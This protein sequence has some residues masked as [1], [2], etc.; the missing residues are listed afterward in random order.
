MFSMLHCFI[1]TAFELASLTLVSFLM[2]FAVL[3][4][5]LN[6][7][8]VCVVLAIRFLTINFNRTVSL[9]NVCL[10]EFLFLLCSVHGAF[11]SADLSFFSTKSKQEIQLNVP[12]LTIKLHSSNVIEHQKW[13]F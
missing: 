9:C 12:L 2:L 8:S 5:D 10:N 3:I 1:N 13:R 4:L 7:S 6:Y 11:I